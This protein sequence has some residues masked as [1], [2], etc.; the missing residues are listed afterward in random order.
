MKNKHK[1]CRYFYDID[2]QYLFL[3]YSNKNIL[4][5]DE[6]IINDFDNNFILNYNKTPGL[7]FV[8]LGLDLKLE[9]GSEIRNFKSDLLIHKILGI[10]DEL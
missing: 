10:T 5:F 6:I 4:N 3:N 9:W 1:F 2:D 7:K 8:E